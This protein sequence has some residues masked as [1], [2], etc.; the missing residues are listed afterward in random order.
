MTMPFTGATG[1]KPCQQCQGAP[2]SYR[3][4][5]KSFLNRSTQLANEIIAKHTRT[6]CEGPVV[7]RHYH[8]YNSPWWLFRPVSFYQPSV[9]YVRDDRNHGRRGNDSRDRG[10]AALVGI[11]AA[12]VGGISL[13][14]T[15]TSI[16]R[17]QDASKELATTREFKR[18][19]AYQARVASPN[20][21]AHISLVRKIVQVN[22]RICS[23]IQNSAAWDLALRIS[24]VVGC[25]VAIAGAIV[26]S[27]YIMMS[28]ATGG[29][30]AGGAM[31][32]KW[33]I[34][35]SDSHNFRE[36]QAL[37]MMIRNLH[38]VHGV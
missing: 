24:L 16:S 21:R 17:L 30:I 9:V 1:A 32:L 19:V 26:A 12:I 38:G 22:E 10:A 37:K 28:G 35:A 8:Y 25:G 13:Y 34:E 7:I 18:E 15:G 3:Q 31:L 23:R 2:I 5:L 36:A 11:T 4:E 20:Q 14:A 29:L 33:G 6:A 27:P